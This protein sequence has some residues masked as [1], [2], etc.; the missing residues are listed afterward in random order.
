VTDSGSTFVNK[1]AALT[2]AKTLTLAGDHLW[3]KWIDLLGKIS[4]ANGRRP[5][6][7]DDPGKEFNKNYLGGQAPAKQVLDGLMK[8]MPRYYGLG[9]D[10]TDAVNQTVDTDE[11][12][13]KWFE[14]KSA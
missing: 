12:I 7:D 9:Q 2:S 3:T 8:I 6:G 4:D 1:D 10:V 5:W 13:A 14:P 11:L